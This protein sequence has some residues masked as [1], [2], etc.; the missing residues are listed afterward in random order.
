[1]SAVLLPFTAGGDI[2][3]DG[4]TGLVERTLAA[5]LVP[6]V[7]MDTGFG[8]VLSAAERRRVLAVASDLC[9]GDPRGDR[10]LAGAHV[11][12]SPG[13]T[14]DADGYRRAFDE[15]AEHGGTPIVFPS[16]GLVAEAEVAEAHAAFA[17]TVDRLYGFELG[18]MFHPAGR[19]WDLDTFTA[20][21]DID[22]I[23]GAKHSSLRRRP[24]LDRLARRDARRPGFRVLTGNDLAIDLVVHGSD[25][26]L[27]LSAFAPDAFAVRDRAFAAGD[28]VGFRE[29][30]DVLQHLGQLAFRRPVPGYRHDAAIFLRRRGWIATDRTHPRSP[31]RP[32][33]DR[34]LLYDLVDRVEV[35]VR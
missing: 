20:V 27:G 8:P 14:L 29:A 10:F 13:A 5:G 23:V 22:R 33:A 31:R 32:D 25:Y 28:E 6:A 19:I 16:F 26:L 12:D 17:R 24:E 34:P 1:M 4:L 7:N 9:P 18:P 30:N 2:D 15:I 21:L 35:L 3:W 11:D